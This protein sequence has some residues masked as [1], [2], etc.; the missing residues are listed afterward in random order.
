MEILISTFFTVGLLGFQQQNVHHEKYWLA[1]ITSVAIAGA[2]Y[3]MISSVANGGNW[4][5]MG[6]GGAA[7]VTSSM[8]IHR[9]Y[10]RK[11]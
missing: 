9:R 11:K 8:V 10:V 6:L 4:L 7:G 2:Q 5:L 3:V 1:A